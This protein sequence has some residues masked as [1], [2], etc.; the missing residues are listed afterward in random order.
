MFGG[1]VVL[2]GVCGCALGVNIYIYIYC[3][4]SVVEVSGY[5]FWGWSVSERRV[6]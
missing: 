1:Y 4:D 6:G 5:R 2:C 3:L